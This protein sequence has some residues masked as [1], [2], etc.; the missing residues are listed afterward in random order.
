MSS[1]CFARYLVMTGALVYVILVLG[2]SCN[3][4]S[5]EHLLCS[6]VITEAMELICEQP[7]LCVYSF[8][9]PADFFV[10]VIAVHLKVLRVFNGK[11]G[12]FDEN[13]PV[14]C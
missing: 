13:S 1:T 3:E 11:T 4:V 6:G 7:C 10:G 9:F 2:L 12:C 14:F 5:D 8:V